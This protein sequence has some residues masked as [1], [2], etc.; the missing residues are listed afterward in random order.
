MNESNKEATQTLSSTIHHLSVQLELERHENKGLRASLARKNK[1]G[2]LGKPLDLHQRKEYH[3]S[4]VIWSPRKLR[5]ARFREKV[6]KT[7][8]NKRLI[9]RERTRSRELV[10]TLPRLKSQTRSVLRERERVKE[11]REKDKAEKETERARKKE[12]SDRRKALQIPQKCKRKATRSLAT[13]TTK[14]KRQKRSGGRVASSVAIEAAP[15][16]AART[17]RG[18]RNIKTPAKYR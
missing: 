18:G 10:I 17:S 12:E 11:Q 2:K 14:N 13:T 6:Y 9:V 1:R 16:Q 8:N 3:S 4:A 15:A 5:E 7:N